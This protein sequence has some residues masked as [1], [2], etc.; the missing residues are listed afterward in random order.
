[1]KKIGR[2]RILTDEQR[3]ANDKAS[4]KRYRTKHPEKIK[5]RQREGLVR[6]A[7]QRRAY[8]KKRYAENKDQIN[9]MAREAYKNGGR[10]KVLKAQA[11]ARKA[12]REAN[13]LPMRAP[14]KPAAQRTREYRERLKK[15][16]PEKYRETLKK[17]YAYIAANIDRY[18][19][20]RR[21][22]HAKLMQSPVGIVVKRLRTRLH[23]EIRFRKRKT[24]KHTSALNLVGC[25]REFLA[26]WIESKFKPGMSWQNRSAWHIDHILPVASF[27]MMDLEEQKKCFHYTNLQP[28]WRSEN[29]AK[30]DRIISH[31]FKAA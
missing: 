13:P 20:H 19:A 18:R 11:A 29:C 16:N 2:P 17:G 26:K 4:M 12:F 23:S 7:E 5:E 24:I 6:Y 1:M 30:G 10:E 27:D 25:S 21:K 8:C 9:A 3:I 15:N 28:L 31:D 14:R 22:A